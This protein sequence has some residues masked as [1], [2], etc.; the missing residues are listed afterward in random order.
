[1]LIIGDSVSASY[2]PHVQRSLADTCDVVRCGDREGYAGAAWHSSVRLLANLGTWLAQ[3]GDAALVHFNCGLHDIM[4]DRRTGKHEVPLDV[5]RA[6][7]GRILMRLRDAC[8]LLV[9]ATI[10][11]VLFE[12]H[13]TVEVF[14]RREEDVHAY[15]ATAADVMAAAGIPVNDLHGVLCRA[16]VAECLRDDGV[17]PTPAAAERLG[18]AVAAAISRL[19]GSPPRHRVGQG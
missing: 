2:T 18:A 8:P 3:H 15:N 13:L 11:P 19:T 10:T 12:R 5:Y 1:V 6:N 4:V 16:G 17:H 14:D 7:L 9:W